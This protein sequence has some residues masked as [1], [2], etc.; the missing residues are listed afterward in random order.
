MIG[1]DGIILLSVFS[2]VRYASFVFS[3]AL[4]FVSFLRLLLPSLIVVEGIEGR[5]ASL[6][7][8]EA[9]K[10]PRFKQSLAWLEW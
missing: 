7:I 9:R 10:D 1:V 2:S 8:K 6:V 4:F 5:T 3:A